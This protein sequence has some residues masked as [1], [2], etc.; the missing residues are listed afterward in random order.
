MRAF[1][2]LMAR[3]GVELNVANGTSVKSLATMILRSIEEGKFVTLRAIGPFALSQALKSIAVANG[4]LAQQGDAL[5]TL[6]AFE[7]RIIKDRVTQE[8]KELTAMRLVIG[9]VSMQLML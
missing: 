9:K 2:A 1:E 8:D 4:E 7:M 6:P 5:W 3:V